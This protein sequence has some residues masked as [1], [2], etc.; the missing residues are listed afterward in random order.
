[1]TNACDIANIPIECS[2]ASKGGM[3]MSER[4]VSV[5]RHVGILGFRAAQ[6]LAAT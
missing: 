4:G 5:A 1:L 2:F 6:I 3:G